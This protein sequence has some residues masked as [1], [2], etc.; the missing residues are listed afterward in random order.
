MS[1]SYFSGDPLETLTHVTI[2]A[3]EE[4]ILPFGERIQ[5]MKAVVHVLEDGDKK[6]QLQAELDQLEGAEQRQRLLFGDLRR[7]LKPTNA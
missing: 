7:S 6:S 3:I 4:D 1:K 2:R 5:A